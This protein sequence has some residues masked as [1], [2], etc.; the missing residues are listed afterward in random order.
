[1]RSRLA[2]PLLL[3]ALLAGACSTEDGG[4]PAAEPP[5]AER[6]DEQTPG[7]ATEASPG[8]D[9]VGD[10]LVEG[11]IVVQAAASLTDAFADVAEAFSA[12]HPDA[13]VVYNFAGSQAL[14]TQIVE[15]AP[16]DVF[17]SANFTQMD[18]VAENGLVVDEPEVFVNNQ[19]AVAVEAG[20]PFGISSLADLADPDLVLVLAAP[21]VPAGSFAAEALEGAGV[22]VT[23]ASLEVDVRSVLSKVELGE[24]D[25][26]IVYTSDL[27]TASDA[28]E[29]VVIPEAENV[30]A[31]YPIAA[32]DEGPNPEGAAAFIDFVLSAEGQAILGECGFVGV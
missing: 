2:V 14:A 4:P 25:A 16:A 10:G 23:P 22:E 30:V 26:G 19:L 12:D 21:D 28:V 5:V 13:T 18:V 31:A 9:A 6:P 1:M 20:N 24:A 27:V 32:L 11:E 29:G 8:S 7:A 15:G 17:A 3:L